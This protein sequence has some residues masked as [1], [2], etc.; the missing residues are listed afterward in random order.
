MNY[1]KNLRKAAMTKRIVLLIC[2]AALLGLVIG[3]LA[4]YTLGVHIR[5]GKNIGS[6]ISNGKENHKEWF[7]TETD[8]TD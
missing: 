8:I 6:N 3:G 4:G 5:R 7:L 2:I 1:S